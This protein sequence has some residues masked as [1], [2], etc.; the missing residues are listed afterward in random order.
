[1][2]IWG[3]AYVLIGA[4]LSVLPIYDFGVQLLHT[5]TV[6][7]LSEN[8]S[9]VAWIWAVAVL[10]IVFCPLVYWAVGYP[11]DIIATQMTGM[12]TLTGTMALAWSAARVV[13]SYILAFVLFF[14]MVWSFVN[15]RNNQ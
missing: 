2:G 1:M 4:S 8:K 10:A 5:K 15:A 12:Y 9:G 14:V 6:K 3:F 11:F 13:I 7:K